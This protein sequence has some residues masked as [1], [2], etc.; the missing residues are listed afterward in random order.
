[1]PC[2]LTGIH[3]SIPC[4]NPNKTLVNISFKFEEGNFFPIRI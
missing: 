3:S 4:N 2:E 1:M